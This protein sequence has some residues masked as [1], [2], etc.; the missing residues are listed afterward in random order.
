MLLIL[1]IDREDL[2]VLL[3]HLFF[4]KLGNKSALTIDTTNCGRTLKSP[5]TF[6]AMKRE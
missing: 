1:V 4:E 6:Q 5:I 2:P 3:S